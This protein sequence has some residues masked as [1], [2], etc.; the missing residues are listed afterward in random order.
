MK[1]VISYLAAFFTLFFVVQVNA[2]IDYEKDYKYYEKIC[3]N[4]S[5]YEINKQACIGF[6]NFKKKGNS[7]IDRQTTSLKDSKLTADKLISLIRDN[8]SL[9]EKKT[10]EIKYNKNKALDNMKKIKRLEV[11]VMDSLETMQFVSDQNQ[12]IDI[13]MASTSLEDLMVRVDGLNN[14]N[15]AN[16]ENIFDLENTTRELSDSQKYI[17]ADIKK[18]KEVKVKQE[19]LLNEF[20]RKEADLYSKMNSGG[21]NGSVFNESISEI[22]LSKINEKSGRWGLPMKHGNVSAGTWY[23]PGGGWHPG[24]DVANKVGTNI[25]A[26]GSGA[27]LSTTMD[28]G[29]YGKHIVIV[30]KKGNYVYT[31][32]Y[33]HL[34]DFVGVNGFKKGDVIAKSGNTGN[35]TGPHVHVEVFRHNTDS[36]ST[37]VN[38]YKKQKDYWFGLGYSGK[39]DC[40]KVCRLEPTNEF[41]LKVGQTY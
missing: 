4:R 27:L 15:K 23:Y 13:I 17:A 20:R 40:N 5:S 11:E 8:N 30:T 35:S 14:I 36:V 12:I 33:G 29:G 25:I 37:V 22:D 26:P 28:G 31:M 6:E 19:Q 9:V 41:R 7:S 18:L 21:G 16:L 24:M 3:S 2:K 32:L 34:S 10:R 39:G 1:R 38:Q